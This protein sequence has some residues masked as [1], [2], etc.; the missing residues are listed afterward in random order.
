MF[1]GIGGYGVAIALSRTGSR[2]DRDRAGHGRRGS[3]LSLALVVP[4]RLVLAARESDFLRHDHAGGGLVLRHPGL[5]A[6]R[7]HR[8]RGRHHLQGAGTSTLA[9]RDLLPGVRRGAGAVPGAAADREFTVRPGAAGDPRERVPRRGAGVSHGHLPDAGQL[10]GRGDGDAGW[11]PLRAMAALHR[12]EYHA[13]LQH[14]DRHPA[15]GG[16]RRHG[17]HVRRG[18]WR[19]HLR[20]GAELPA[21]SDEEHSRVRCRAFLAAARPVPSGPLA[22]VAGGAVRAVGVLLPGRHQ[23]ASCALRAKA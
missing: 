23:P 3:C 2:L 18:H 8:R 5:A 17:H 9:R 7:L 1:F 15:D 14:H 11:C 4:G 16:D 6:L 10:P 20:G 21:G 12:A 13:R 19:G 22:A